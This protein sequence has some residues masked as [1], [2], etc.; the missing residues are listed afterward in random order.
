MLFGT[1]IAL[2]VINLTILTLGIMKERRRLE[3]ECNLEKELS[4]A[5]SNEVSRIN[6][7]HQD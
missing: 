1:L 7:E 5:L 2:T 4:I 6:S 3:I